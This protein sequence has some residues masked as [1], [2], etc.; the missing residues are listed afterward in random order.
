MELPGKEEAQGPPYTCPECGRVFDNF[1]KYT[2]HLSHHSK[3][4]RR[5]LESEAEQGASEEQRQEEPGV[6]A[7]EPAAE[8]GAGARRVG[9]QGGGG[10]DA[11]SQVVSKPWEVEVVEEALRFL[12]E[13]LP[14]VY[15]IEKYAKAIVESLRDNP[16]P[17][18]NPNALHAFIKSLAPRAHDSHLF[19]FAISPLYAR[20]PNLPEAVAKLMASGY[21]APTYYATPYGYQHQVVPY[22]QP[23]HQPLYMSLY[24]TNPLPMYAPPPIYYPPA[25][26]KSPRTYKIIVDGQEI[27]TDEAGFLAWQ[28]F[29]QERRERELEMKKIEI[30]MKKLELEM[31]RM[32]REEDRRREDELSKR[33]EKLTERVEQQAEKLAQEKEDKFKMILSTLEKTQT[34]VMETLRAMQQTERTLLEEKHKAEMEALRKEIEEFKRRPGF[35]DELNYLSEVARRLGFSRTGRTSMDLID[36]LFDRIDQRF[37]QI[38]DRIDLRVGQIISRVPL[39]QGPRVTRAPTERARIAEEVERRLERAGE[40]IELENEMLRLA[41]ELTAE[42][43]ARSR[44]AEAARTEAAIETATKSEATGQL[45]AGATGESRG[46]SGGEEARAV[47]TA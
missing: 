39:Q 17:L 41:A 14:K 4:R 40:L 46:V 45:A 34:M 16:A 32:E 2:G 12:D 31:K 15:G 28:R 13:R 36:S 47:I 20:F 19:V 5:S 23:Y 27:E 43:A 30:E 29:L 24:H 7:W 37:A 42:Q 21:T 26:P 6:G 1:Y 9:G 18:A 38:A 22:Y 25:P 11:G 3:A 10:G 33:V 44:R 8:Q 35:L